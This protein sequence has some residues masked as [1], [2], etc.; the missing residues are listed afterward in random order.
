[1]ILGRDINPDLVTDVEGLFCV[2]NQIYTSSSASSVPDG[3]LI[4]LPE[5]LAPSSNRPIH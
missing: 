4:P 3:R 5:H 1:M 2:V